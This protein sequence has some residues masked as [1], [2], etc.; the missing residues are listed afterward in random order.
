MALV[1]MVLALGLVIAGGE[2]W[3]LSQLWEQHRRMRARLDAVD[4]RLAMGEASAAMVRRAPAFVLPDLDGRPTSLA[5]LLGRGRPV[6]LVFTDPRCG[7]CGELLPAVAAWQRDHGDRLTIAMISGGDVDA[8]RGHV[9]GHVIAPV[10]LQK[11]LEAVR[12]YG[13]ERAPA[14]VLINA[15][16]TLAATPAYGAPDI[17]ALVDGAL[18]HDVLASRPAPSTPTPL[19]STAPGGAGDARGMTIE[20]ADIDLAELR[21]APLLLL[22][23]NPNCGHCQRLLPALK[24]RLTSPLPDEPRVVIV[25][26]GTREAIRAAGLSA[27]ILIDGDRAISQAFGIRGTPSALLFDAHGHAAR[28]V[29]RGAQ[30]VESLLGAGAVSG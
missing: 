14:A 25:T 5:A 16:G 29:A 6:M 13:L 24:D 1:S 15:D 12:A 4:A 30:A 3:L 20:A 26:G 10:L 23:W 28:P 9:A 2:A 21:G 11:G 18:A 19:A 17:R 7:P 8:N 22:F 27:P